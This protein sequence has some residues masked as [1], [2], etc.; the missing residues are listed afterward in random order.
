MQKYNAHVYINQDNEHISLDDFVYLASDVDARDAII[1][2]AFRQLLQDLP[3]NRDW[4]NPDI[5]RVMREF[6][7]D[8]R[9]RGL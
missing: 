6:D 3:K 7:S 2:W 4:L 5:E 9:A 1:G 8:R